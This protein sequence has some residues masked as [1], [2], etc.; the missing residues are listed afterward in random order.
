[1]QLPFSWSYP[2]TLGPFQTKRLFFASIAPCVSNQLNQGWG[3]SGPRATSGPPQRFQWQTEA[4]R[5]K[6][7]I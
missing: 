6:L 5:K 3:I 2:S 1:M 7:Q 4:F